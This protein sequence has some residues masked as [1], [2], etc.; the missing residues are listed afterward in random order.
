MRWEKYKVPLLQLGLIVSGAVAIV[1]LVSVFILNARLNSIQTEQTAVRETSAVEERSAL[2]QQLMVYGSSDE[3]AL[4]MTGSYAMQGLAGND[5][6][7][8]ESEDVCAASD[9]DGRYY[10]WRMTDGELLTT[11]ANTSYEKAVLIGQNRILLEDSGS[12]YCFDYTSGMQLWKWQFPYVDCIWQYDSRTE[13]IYAISQ[14]PDMETQTVTT[15]GGQN[16][17]DDDWNDEDWDDEDWD[18]EDWD[19]EDRNNSRLTTEQTVVTSISHDI[20]VLSVNSLEVNYIRPTDLLAEERNYKKSVISDITLSEDGTHLLMNGCLSD[21]ENHNERYFSRVFNLSDISFVPETTETSGTEY[22]DNTEDSTDTSE[23]LKTSEIVREVS[24]SYNEGNDVGYRMTSRWIDNDSLLQ[25]SESIP[26][27]E[28]SDNSEA[29]YGENDDS[30]DTDAAG[31]EVN[32]K[33]RDELDEEPETVEWSIRK[34]TLPYAST[35]W[36]VHGNGGPTDDPKLISYTDGENTYIIVALSQCAL[37]LGS[38]TGQEIGA[39]IDTDDFIYIEP[40]GQRPT[41]L[42]TTD[43]S[44][45]QGKRHYGLGVSD[46][47][48]VRK[49]KGSYFVS[50]ENSIFIYTMAGNVA[51]SGI[52]LTGSDEILWNRAVFSADG[53]Y[54]VLSG[55]RYLRLYRT[56]DGTRLYQNICSVSVGADAAFCGNKLCHLDATGRNLMIY[57]PATG[58]KERVLLTGLAATQ[59]TQIRSW[60]DQYMLIASEDGQHLW[61]IDAEAMAI[62]R[63]ISAK[64][65]CEMT[66]LDMKKSTAMYCRMS[67]DANYLVYSMQVSD[68]AGALT[69]KAYVTDLS[70]GETLESD[71]LASKLDVAAEDLPALNTAAYAFSKDGR[72][73][74]F[75]GANNSIGVFDLKEAAFAH[76]SNC[77]DLSVQPVFTPSGNVVCVTSGGDVCVMSADSGSFVAIDEEGKAYES[78]DIFSM[79]RLAQ[80]VSLSFDD[81]KMY[82]SGVKNGKTFIRVYEISDNGVLTPET[83]IPSAAAAG[84]ERILMRYGDAEA[85]VFPY[86]TLSELQNMA[87]TE[88]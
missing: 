60:G 16:D 78:R 68:D 48:A 14:N 29:D 26:A 88:E 52:A 64:N 42:I 33:G 12:F 66:G 71:D 59:K 53:A 9:A 86:L 20:Y 22:V 40:K 85:E 6:I 63:T 84:A 36:R 17:G 31:N 10:V 57:D 47:K 18:D 82:A 81:S 38:Q 54:T 58:N 25:Y 49:I 8:N 34:R 73:A 37:T 13:T 75:T 2:E 55:Q 69:L 1:S 45:I 56:E 87:A 39:T 72:Y 74:L 27:E 65:L 67:P 79:D 43:G 3:K 50:A 80:A 7:C 41:M 77:G 83:E 70:S 4:V 11:Y 5:L 30:P 21:P 61:I 51:K 15:A 32:I 28:S 19:D 62:S 24:A 23:S 46:I 35:I 76:E 44:V